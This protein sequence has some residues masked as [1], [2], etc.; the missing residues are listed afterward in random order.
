M[1]ESVG[2]LSELLSAGIS[3]FQLRLSIRLNTWINSYTKRGQ[4]RILW[5]FTITAFCGILARLIISITMPD[6]SKAAKHYMPPE[7]HL[8]STDS[9]TT[10][11][12]NYGKANPGRRNAATIY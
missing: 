10:K 7:I 11:R 4:K 6:I 2:H 12:Q 5:A 3:K 9:L 8:K 1:S